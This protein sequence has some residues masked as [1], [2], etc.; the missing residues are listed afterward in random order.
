MGWHY[1]S[2]TGSGY[3][4]IAIY[5]SESDYTVIIFKYDADKVSPDTYGSFGNDGFPL[6]GDVSFRIQAVEDGY[7]TYTGKYYSSVYEGVGSVWS[8]FTI[9]MPSHDVYKEKNPSG[10]FKPNFRP[11]SVA[12]ELS[13]P[14]GLPTSEPAR[15]PISSEQLITYLFAITAT[16]CIIT[17]PLVIVM[18]HNKQQQQRKTRP[19]STNQNKTQIQHKTA[20]LQQCS[21]L[22]RHSVL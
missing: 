22:N 4:P 12:P 13:N 5:Q 15:P 1:V 20:I 9:S 2:D 14:N 11:T 3:L 19:T 21:T 17:I 6:W 7:F 18:Y 8:E 16:V 10:V